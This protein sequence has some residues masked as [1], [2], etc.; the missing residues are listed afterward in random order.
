MPQTKQ[1][2]QVKALARLYDTLDQITERL[3]HYRSMKPIVGLFG[4]VVDFEEEIKIL[5]NRHIATVMEIKVLGKLLNVDVK[6]I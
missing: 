4:E 3:N 5:S 2:K 1:E 6:V